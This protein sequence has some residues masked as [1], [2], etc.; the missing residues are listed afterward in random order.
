MP[1]AFLRSL[2]AGSCIG[3][4][5]EYSINDKSQRALAISDQIIEKIAGRLDHEVAF[6]GILVSKELQKHAIEL[7]PQRPGGLGFLEE[8]L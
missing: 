1:T 4:E 5:H 7:I 6:G 8:R 3:T 2:A